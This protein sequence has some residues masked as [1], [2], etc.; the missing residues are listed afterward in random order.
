M[1]HHL[2]SRLAV[3]L[4]LIAGSVHAQSPT[5]R[6]KEADIL[7]LVEM[8]GSKKMAQD[9]YA[10]LGAHMKTAILER[11]PEG[12]ESERCRQVLERF[13]QKLDARFDVDELVNRMM[14]IYDKY[15]THE[16]IKALIAFYQTPVGQRLLEVTPQLTQESFEVGGKW[17]QETA[18]DVLAELQAEFPELEPPGS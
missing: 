13:W 18:R 1:K 10:M 11:F 6:A 4:F 7:R 9:M 5:D 15:L 16:E 8:T 12:E 17:G 2:L 14:P 3:V